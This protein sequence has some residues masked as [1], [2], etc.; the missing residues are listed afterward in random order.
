MRVYIGRG[1]C[2]DVVLPTEHVTAFAESLAE[3]GD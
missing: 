3:Y 1:A 2:V